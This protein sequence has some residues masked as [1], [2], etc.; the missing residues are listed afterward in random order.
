MKL[1]LTGLAKE[2]VKKNKLMSKEASTFAE[3][4]SVFICNS[5]NG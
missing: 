3:A 1:I 5:E 2:T 4:L